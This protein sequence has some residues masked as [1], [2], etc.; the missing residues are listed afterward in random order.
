LGKWQGRGKACMTPTHDLIATATS[1]QRWLAK[2]M[3]K[4]KRC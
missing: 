3:Q 2:L 4:R 1:L